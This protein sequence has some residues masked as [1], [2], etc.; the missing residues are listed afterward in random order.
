MEFL[1]FW[2]YIY[3]YTY[4][5]RADKVFLS[6]RIM[7]TERNVVCLKTKIKERMYFNN[8]WI[9]T[10]FKNTQNKELIVLNI[11]VYIYIQWN[12]SKLANFGSTQNGPN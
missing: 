12:I 11:G 3:I 9:K 2:D 7:S 4:T 5:L 6:I 8:F 10:T 1:N